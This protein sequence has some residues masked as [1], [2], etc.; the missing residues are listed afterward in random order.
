[1]RQLN[2]FN[3]ISCAKQRILI[4]VNANAHNEYSNNAFRVPNVSTFSD[5]ARIFCQPLYTL[6][7]VTF[8]VDVH[9]QRTNN[10]NNNKD[11]RKKEL[12]TSFGQ[13]VFNWANTPK[14]AIWTANTA[15]T[16]LTK[17]CWL[18]RRLTKLQFY[19]INTSFL[20]TFFSRSLQST[21]DCSQKAFAVS[22][23]LINRTQNVTSIHRLTITFEMHRRQHKHSKCKL[24][25][26][27]LSSQLDE[28]N[29][30]WYLN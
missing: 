4:L 7:S 23:L 29:F 30:N 21:A 1:M 20:I 10:A 3:S 27:Q 11:T 26:L 8:Y 5:T 16:V 28:L 15:G 6:R 2:Q 19:R 24:I 14:L 9:K 18:C 22:V 13:W 25:S 17:A 12:L